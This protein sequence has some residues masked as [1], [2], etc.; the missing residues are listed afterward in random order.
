MRTWITQ[1]RKGLLEFC[2]LNAISR[3]ETYGYELVQRLKGVEQLALTESTAYPILARLK[4]DGYV[5]VR[6]APS[7]SGPPRRYFS[8]TA[9][10]R[11]R[12]GE[13]N[14]YWDGLCEALAGIRKTIDG[15]HGNEDQ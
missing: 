4:Q 15:R 7:S 6:D 9:L 1:L 2:V 3:G 5:K 10:G 11:H 14:A 13:M 8:L 12:I